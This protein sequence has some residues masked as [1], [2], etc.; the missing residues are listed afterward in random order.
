MGAWRCYDAISCSSP[1]KWSRCIA[2]RLVVWSFSSKRGIR[3]TIADQQKHPHRGEPVFGI[4]LLA[5]YIFSTSKSSQSIS[6]YGTHSSH[7]R[8]C[9]SHLFWYSKRE[10]NPLWAFCW[11]QKAT[12]G[13]SVLGYYSWSIYL[14]SRDLR[15]M[16]L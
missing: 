14:V 13:S 4:D 11:E 8:I 6:G 10:G 15:Y 16:L 1:S 5:G 3:E 9:M 12:F 7:W 2:T